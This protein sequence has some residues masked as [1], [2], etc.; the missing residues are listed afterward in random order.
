MPRPLEVVQKLFLGSICAI[1][2]LQHALND[3]FWVTSW[4]GLTEQHDSAQC[5]E[6]LLYQVRD[7]HFLQQVIQPTPQDMPD[8]EVD[9]YS[10][11]KYLPADM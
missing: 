8:A 4:H 11:A 1:E 2:V 6:H 10:V 3:P 9:R 7:S 5:L